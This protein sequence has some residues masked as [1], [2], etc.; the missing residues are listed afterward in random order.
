MDVSPPIRGGVPRSGRVVEGTVGVR[1]S[2]TE[3]EVR[4]GSLDHPL[5]PSSERRGKH[6]RLLAVQSSYGGKFKSHILSDFKGS[7]PF[8][9]RE[10][11]FR[12]KT[13]GVEEL[14]KQ[15]IKEY[16]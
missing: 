2:I 8:P 12:R 5:I 4:W 11:R 14:T 9:V 1:H 10:K 15:Y 6:N 13:T 16:I 7:V 3:F